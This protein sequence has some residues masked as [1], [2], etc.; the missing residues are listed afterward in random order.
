MYYINYSKTNATVQ[1][2]LLVCSRPLLNTFCTHNLIQ[3]RCNHSVKTEWESRRGKMMPTSHYESLSWCVVYTCGVVVTL[4]LRR[5][6]L[7]GRR[8]WGCSSSSR[9]KRL[10]FELRVGWGN[11]CGQEF[12]NSAN[13][14]PG[15]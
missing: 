1:V 5:G 2:G 7:E 12:M 8:C 6:D 11:K 14:A 4:W 3:L 10:L 13:N 9:N 15:I